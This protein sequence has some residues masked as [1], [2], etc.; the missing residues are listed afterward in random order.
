MFIQKFLGKEEIENSKSD[1]QWGAEVPFGPYLAIAG[2]IYYNGASFVIDAWFYPISWLF[3][4]TS[5]V[6]AF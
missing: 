4:N 3:D 1:I 5:I 2:I 6:G